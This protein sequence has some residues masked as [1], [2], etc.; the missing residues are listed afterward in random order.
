MVNQIVYW[1]I[2][3]DGL[4]LYDLSPNV[5]SRFFNPQNIRGSVPSFSALVRNGGKKGWLH[6]AH[7]HRLLVGFLVHRAQ[8]HRNYTL[9]LDRKNPLNI[10]NSHMFDPA[11]SSLMPH[12]C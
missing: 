11:N 9:L 5:L 3:K 2:R 12:E 10:S 4:E 8:P 7:R 6:Y 1:I